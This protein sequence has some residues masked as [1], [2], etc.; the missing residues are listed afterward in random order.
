[1]TGTIKFWTVKF[2]GDIWIV[3]IWTV[4]TELELRLRLG[5]GLVMTVQ[6]MTVQILTVQLTHIIR[7]QQ[8]HFLARVYCRQ[9][10]GWIKMPFGMDNG[11]TCRPKPHCVR[12][13]PSSPIRGTAA[14][15]NFGRG[16]LWPNG[17]MDQNATWYG[18]RHQRKRYCVSLDD[19][20]R[21]AS[22]FSRVLCCG[23][24]TQYSHLVLICCFIMCMPFSNIFKTKTL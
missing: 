14:P 5:L 23:N 6:F 15:L 8:P 3:E 24:S 9:T 16:L 22:A 1:V 17:W 20:Y 13:E 10:A 12:W 4:K 21:L 18:G 11:G 19:T 7:E 2:P